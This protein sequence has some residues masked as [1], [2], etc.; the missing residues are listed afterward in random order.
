MYPILECCL[1]THV[2]CS[3][4]ENTYV[5]H[6]Y[7]WYLTAEYLI[8]DFRKHLGMKYNVILICY[9]SSNNCDQE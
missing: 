3:A 6:V 5:F 9:Y 4:S 8:T 2:E 1:Q 7:F